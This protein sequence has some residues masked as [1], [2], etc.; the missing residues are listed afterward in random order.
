MI[1]TSFSYRTFALKVKAINWHQIGN[2]GKY[3]KRW[4]LGIGIFEISLGLGMWMS[5]T[6]RGIVAKN[7]ISRRKC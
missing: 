6:E 7:K 3:S 2:S 5:R 1:S 4:N